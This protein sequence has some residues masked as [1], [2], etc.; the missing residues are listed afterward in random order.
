MSIVIFPSILAAE[1]SEEKRRIEEG[2]RVSLRPS[3]GRI[4]EERRAEPASI[5]PIDLHYFIE[6]INK[7]IAFRDDASKALVI[8]MGVESQFIDLDSQ[9]TYL[10]QKNLLPKRF[11]KG[12]VCQGIMSSGNTRGIVEEEEL[13]SI[14]TRAGTYIAKTGK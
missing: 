7:R 6:Q 13:V 10:K 4:F 14:F 1:S 11:E 3:E 5:D 12:L 9:I 2:K 8:L